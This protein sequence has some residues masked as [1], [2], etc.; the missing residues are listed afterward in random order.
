MKAVSRKLWLIAAAAGIFCMLAMLYWLLHDEAAALMSY[1][2]DKER[3]PLLFIALYALLPMVGFPISAFLV[4]LGIKFG[5]WLGVLIMFGGMPIHLFVALFVSHSFLRSWLYRLFEKLDYRLPKIPVEREAW[6]GFVFMAMPGLS[7]SLKNYI[8]ALSGISKR[9]FFLCGFLVQGIMG[10][11]LVI[12]GGAAAGKS[13]VLLAA[14]LVL[15]L[16]IYGIF[17]RIRKRHRL[18]VSKY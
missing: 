7:Y 12:A 14:V 10:I 2:M 1:A 11:P 16:L 8:L 3:H 6:F 13:L 5:S 18:N 17:Y 9:V 15:L 4:L